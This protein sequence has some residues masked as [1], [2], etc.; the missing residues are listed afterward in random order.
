M[1]TSRDMSIISPE[2]ARQLWGQ[3]QSPT[4]LNNV[5]PIEGST[6]RP[7]TRLPDRRSPLTSISSFSTIP[8]NVSCR[9]FPFSVSCSPSPRNSP[10]SLL[11][12]LCGTRLWRLG[13]LARYLPRRFLKCSYTVLN[14]G[15][16]PPRNG[17]GMARRPRDELFLPSFGMAIA[18]RRNAT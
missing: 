2:E 15:H 3:D 18:Y 9:H 6:V 10:R 16:F 12:L 4:D 8:D 1:P 5:F 17:R 13:F 11:P 14:A 7:L